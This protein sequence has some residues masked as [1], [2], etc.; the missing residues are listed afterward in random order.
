MTHKNSVAKVPFGG[1]KGIIFK[2]GKKS[3]EML[4]SYADFLNLLE[5]KY[6]SAEDIG[7]SLK[8]I[9]FIKQHTE[10]V[11]DN[12]DP[13]P[14]TAKGIFYAIKRAISFSFSESLV[15]K[16][17]AIQGAGSVGSK[18]ADHLSKAGAMVYISDIDNSKLKII[19]DPNITIVDNAFEMQCDVFS[20]CAVGAI[21]SRSSI[22]K[23][24]CKIIAGGANNQLLNESVADDLHANGIT[25]IPDILINSGGVIGLTKDIM[26]RNEEQAES[27]LMNIAIRVEQAMGI[28]KDQSMSIQAALK[29]N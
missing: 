23:L 3:N 25:Y 19:S 4:K 15:G 14:Y 20:P 1:G 26:G 2:E 21:F 6:I 18:L 12:V 10:Y 5:G 22:E 9:R 8:D 28:A 17:I 7:I 13:G 29:L 24:N 16:K 11:F 27:E